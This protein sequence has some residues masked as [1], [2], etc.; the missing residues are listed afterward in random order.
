MEQKNK[1]KFLI[2]KAIPFESGTEY[3]KNP[4]QDTCY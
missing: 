2:L 1:K 3:S 4:E